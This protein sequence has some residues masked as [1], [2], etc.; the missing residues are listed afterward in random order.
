MYR[1]MKELLR[2]PSGIGE[3][4]Q[5]ASVVAWGIHYARGMGK[6]AETPKTLGVRAE[7]VKKFLD[8][9]ALFLI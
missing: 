7:I 3:A 2:V 1:G 6:P 9:A 4:R 5:R 8:S